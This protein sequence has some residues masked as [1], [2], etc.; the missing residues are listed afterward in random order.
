[1][2]ASFSL[3]GSVLKLRGT[4]AIDKAER[5]A[6]LAGTIVGSD[7]DDRVREHVRLLR[8]RDQAGQLPIGMIE[9]AGIGRLQPGEETLFVRLR[10][11]QDRRRR[12]DTSIPR[13]PMV[14]LGP[15]RGGFCRPSP[16]R[17]R[18]GGL[19]WESSLWSPE[20]AV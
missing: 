20:N 11:L 1:M 19:V 4:G 16:A 5:A 9:H 7:E 10:I 18:R 2:R 8:E 6:L 3:K 17:S 12:P 15:F 14:D 13:F